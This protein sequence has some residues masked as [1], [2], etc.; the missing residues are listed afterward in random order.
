RGVDRVLNGEVYRWRYPYSEFNR[1]FEEPMLR[2]F[3]ERIAPG[4]T[5]LDVGAS[6]GLFSV[7]AGRTVGEGGRVFSFEPSRIADVLGDHL[8]L[9][10]VA[11]RVEIVR[12]V[13]SDEVGE[14]VFWE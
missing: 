7:V 13:V 10:G 6:F 11:E 2:L 9:N 4:S 5:V 1:T 12:I 3:Q 8:E 14:V